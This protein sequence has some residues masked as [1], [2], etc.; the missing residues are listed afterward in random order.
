MVLEVTKGLYGKNDVLSP[1]MC[2]L[3]KTENNTTKSPNILLGYE[4]V[5]KLLTSEY[6]SIKDKVR[7]NKVSKLLPETRDDIQKKKRQ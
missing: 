1:L 5:K 6:I 4:T 2:D 7:E 3:R